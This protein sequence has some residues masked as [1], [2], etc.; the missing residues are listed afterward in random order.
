MLKEFLVSSIVKQIKN[1]LTRFARRYRTVESNG[2][3]YEVFSP[4]TI[5]IYTVRLDLKARTCFRWQL[6]GI[7]CGHALAVS[8]ERGDDPQI[9]AKTFFRLD[10]FHST[11]SGPIFPPNVNDTVITAPATITEV[12][13]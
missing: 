5:S 10:T 8:L 11:Y 1:L 13:P 3:V 7:P 4:E 2:D 9:Y 12:P 6:S